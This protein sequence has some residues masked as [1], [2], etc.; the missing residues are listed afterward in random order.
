MQLI[1]GYH[2]NKYEEGTVK[3]VNAQRKQDLRRRLG[4][5]GGVFWGGTSEMRSE[6]PIGTEQSGGRRN[7]CHTEET[8]LF[9]TVQWMHLTL[10]GRLN[11]SL[12]G[13]VNLSTFRTRC[14]HETHSVCSKRGCSN[15]TQDIPVNL[16]DSTVIFLQTLIPRPLIWLCRGIRKP[17]VERLWSSEVKLKPNLISGAKRLWCK[18]I[19]DFTRYQNIQQEMKGKWQ[20]MKEKGNLFLSKEDSYIVNKINWHP[21][22]SRSNSK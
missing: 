18:E 16:F 9:R 22:A 21:N 2:S 14:V 3:R 6:A 7:T 12:R 19:E 15:L 10:L 1:L 13:K 20:I 8:S 17:P 5:M 11:S 4:R